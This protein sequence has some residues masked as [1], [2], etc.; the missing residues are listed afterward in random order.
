M[1]PVY[2]KM[3]K[4]T[5]LYKWEKYDAG[6]KWKQGS[7]WLTDERIEYYYWTQCEVIWQD[8]TPYQGNPITQV[9]GSVGEYPENNI[10]TDGYW[11]VYDGS[12]ILGNTYWQYDW[13]NNTVV[14]SKN[15]TEYP[16]EFIEYNVEYNGEYYREYQS[17]YEY[18]GEG[19]I[20]YTPEII[21]SINEDTYPDNGR[22]GEYWYI[23]IK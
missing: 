17:C 3:P 18:I 2:S 9:T 6:Y 1:S 13:S 10:H 12:Y 23:K 20:S 4:N 21:I 5:K 16:D 22:Y 7:C 19:P 8:G 15:R 14:T 11:Y